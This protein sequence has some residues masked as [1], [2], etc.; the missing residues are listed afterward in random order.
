MWIIVLS[1]VMLSLGRGVWRCTIWRGQQRCVLLLL[2]SMAGSVSC[3]DIGVDTGAGTDTGTEVEAD[4]DTDTDT[5][6]DAGPDSGPDIGSDGDTD[7]DSDKDTDTDT[8]TD[9]GSD[10]DT[11]KW[12]FAWTG[13]PIVDS[14]VY[15]EPSNWVSNQAD[16]AMG[17]QS[18]VTADG[19][20][21]QLNWTFGNGDRDKWVQCY[22][23][24]PEPISLS[25]SDIVGFDF[26]GSDIRTVTDGDVVGEVGFELK[27]EDGSHAAVMRFD[28][29]ARLERWAKRV[30]VLKKQFSDSD[31]VDW[32]GIKVISFAVYGAASQSD[33]AGVVTMTNL[34]SS[35][36]TEWE[37]AAKRENVS[38][39]ET[40]DIASNAIAAL[41]QRQTETGLL[42]TWTEDDTSWLYGQGLALKAL[43]LAGNW[44]GDGAA[45]ADASAEAAEKLAL[46]LADS[47]NQAL[48]GFWPRTWDASTGDV[49]NWTETDNTVWMGDAP[50]PLIGLQSYYKKT[51]DERVRPAIEQFLAFLKPLIDQEGRIYTLNRETGAQIAVTSNEAYAAVLLGLYESGEDVLA[52]TVWEHVRTVGWDNELNV[53]KE[54]ETS[55]RLVL[56]ANTWLAPFMVQHGE[57]DLALDALSLIGK[58]LYTEG[59]GAPFGMD[60]IVPLAIWYEGTL[61]Y[62]SAGG[63]G[64]EGLFTGLADF[65]NPDGT[66]PHYNEVL[67]AM[68]GIWAVDWSSLDGT[69]W[70]YY[71]ASG[72]SPFDI[73][74]GTPVT[75]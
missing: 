17:D 30:A 9:T 33:I 27:F 32:S 3:V 59:G 55:N 35:S 70:L 20:A 4:G 1:K 71:A 48:E 10:T 38:S 73:V 22:L 64:S 53:W 60:G 57:S 72:N 7:S 46:F 34:I 36:T 54:G 15:S 28:N 58:T 56:F 45:P 51:G 52:E 62:I 5:H 69:S 12:S 41:V 2:I 74:S 11:N 49:I 29:I 61:S 13:A 68:A 50:W 24:L 65:I 63:P 44:E 16:A 66:V 26:K 25:A 21:I 23:P 19:N 75:N 31:L 47:Q 18:V 67:D 42:T 37:K 8:D 40:E 6:S 39:D 43:T 14:E